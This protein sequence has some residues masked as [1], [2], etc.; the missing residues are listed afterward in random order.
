MKNTNR[1]VGSLSRSIRTF[2]ILLVS[3]SMTDAT[4]YAQSELT[5]NNLPIPGTS[6]V[7]SMLTKAQA[8]TLLENG[9]AS[10]KW[11]SDGNL[12]VYFYDQ[13]DK[14]SSGTSGKGST[15]SFSSNDGEL[16]IKDGNG[17]V[18]WRSNTNSAKTLKLQSDRNLV[19]LNS[20]GQEVWRSGPSRYLDANG[21]PVVCESR[22]NDPYDYTVPSDTRFQYLNVYARGADGGKRQV[23]ESTGATRFTVNGGEGATIMAQFSIGT[24]SN[25]IPPGSV[26]RIIVGLK[27]ATRTNQNTSG[28]PGGGGTGILYSKPTDDEWHL[29]VAA[30]G[31]G[32]A[33]SDCCSVKRAGHAAVTGTSG[34]QGGNSGGA[35]GIDGSYGGDGSQHDNTGTGGG[36]AYEG[37]PSGS[38]WYSGAPGWEGARTQ[39]SNGSYTWNKTILP[40]G[41]TGGIAVGETA[42][43]DTRG[44]YGFGGGGDGNTSGGGGGG[45]SGGGGGKDYYPG[46][47]GASFV[48]A[49]SLST[50]KIQNNTTSSTRDGS[51]VLRLTNIAK[52]SNNIKFAY[53][54]SK[55][56]DDYG[57]GTSNGNNIQTYTCTGNPNQQWFFNLEDRT[58]R[59]MVNTAKCLDLDHSNTGNGTN[60]QLWDCNNT[61]AQRW[62]YNGLYK[63]IHSTLNCDK[64]FD[65]AN[66]SASTANV[67]LQLW[68]CQ[69][70]NNNQKW[71]IDGATAVSNV[72]NMK[73][74]VPVLSTSFALHSHTG[75]ESGS[76]I[77]LWTKDNTNTAEQWYFDGLAIKMRDHQNLCID[78][79]QSNNIQL[80]NCNG[81]NAQKW[82][83]DGMTQSIRSVVNPDKCMQ[84]ELN[85]DG[86]YGKRSNVDIQD[87]NGSEAQQFLIQ[88]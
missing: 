22:G 20:F 58:I 69:Y 25:Q 87:C 76:N 68:D 24:G 60:I 8:G 4:L 39:N 3:I 16:Q 9:R 32:G 48:N 62:V 71:E 30:G 44:G 67:N 61:E 51:V 54:T 21:Y 15:L 82:L 35:G 66:G 18:I 28:C 59:S 74:I 38:D 80:Y 33:Y 6:N 14:W 11:Q 85:T 63:T 5:V 52:V 47:G 70:T 37:D 36:G 31:G 78:L 64:C 53:N 43:G 72:S 55:C 2:F 88:E 49:M 42:W 13:D 50:V 73:H 84:I 57:S 83:Y 86:V 19:L 1:N 81:T 26:V 29:L 41:G 23:K 40:M 12:V 56:I 79:S 65:A 77:Q 27:G 34:D 10:L 46:G 75:A 7:T 17:S 45:Y